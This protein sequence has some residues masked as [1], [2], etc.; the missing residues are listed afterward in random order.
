MGNHKNWRQIMQPDWY[1]DT[2]RGMIT[3]LAGG[4]KEAV[5]WIGRKKKL[6]D[7]GTTESSLMNRLRNESDQ[8]FPL[9]W[10]LLLD[11]AGGTHHVADAVAKASGGVFVPLVELEDI[12]DGE[13]NSRL[14]RAMEWLGKHSDYIRRAIEDGVI[15]DAE[16]K[17]IDE[18]LYL[19]IATLQE[20]SSL[21]FR[22][23]CKQEMSDARECAAPG[24][25]ADKSIGMEKSA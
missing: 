17:Q 3:G 15:D 11:Q 12:D 14:L 4:Y 18:N 19:T 22:V 7:N 16:R 5:S 9:G 1:T 24:V 2:V 25:V 23:F 6:G 8:V 10:A 13:I 20:H 21:L